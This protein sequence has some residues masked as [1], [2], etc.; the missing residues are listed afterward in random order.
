[1][2]SDNLKFKDIFWNSIG[3]I[4]YSAVSLLVSIV[5][6]NISGSI[7]GGIF[8]FGFSTLGRLVYITSYFGI[9][10][11][12]I[13]DIKYKYSFKDYISFGFKTAF[14]A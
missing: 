1:M 2:R 13:V 10:P 6:I 11:M 9:R 14:I 8:S 12:H 4:T 7:E 3:T 5:I